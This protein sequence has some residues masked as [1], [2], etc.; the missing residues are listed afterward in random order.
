MR[1]DGLVGFT[2]VYLKQCYDESKSDDEIDKEVYNKIF[3]LDTRLGTTASEQLFEGHREFRERVSNQMKKQL[4]ELGG[5]ILR[6]AGF[7]FEK[8]KDYDWI[9][10]ETNYAGFAEY[11]IAE[12]DSRD[13]NSDVDSD[14]KSD[15]DNDVATVYRKLVD[16]DAVHG[17]DPSLQLFRCIHRTTRCD[18]IKV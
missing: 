4:N 3:E 8:W 6:D 7:A 14:V 5:F 9:K 15:V 13:A 2:Q 12:Y 16:I 18:I 17:T 11:F 1:G 10:Q